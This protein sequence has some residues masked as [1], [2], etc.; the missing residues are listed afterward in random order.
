MQLISQC[1]VNSTFSATFNR[2]HKT[3]AFS[4]FYDIVMISPLSNRSLTVISA[5]LIECYIM[6][7]D[8][9]LTE[10]RETTLGRPPAHSS[11]RK[12]TFSSR[13]LRRT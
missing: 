11:A 4:N 7:Y 1:R 2:S 9:C 8:L 6:A 10:R 13:F 12:S 3:W 5:C